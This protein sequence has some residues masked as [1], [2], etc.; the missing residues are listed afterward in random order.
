MTTKENLIAQAEAAVRVAKR[1]VQAGAWKEIT[2]YQAQ[3][4]LN[5]LMNEHYVP[6]VRKTIPAVDQ[7]S[8]ARPMNLMDESRQ[9]VSDAQAASRKVAGLS[10]LLH[11]TTGQEK[12]L[13]LKQL[14]VSNI[15][16][17]QKWS[18]YFYFKRNGKKMD[19]LTSEGKKEPEYVNNPEFLKLERDKN[20]AMQKRSRLKGRLERDVLSDK[21]RNEIE[22]LFAKTNMEIAAMVEKI[23]QLKDG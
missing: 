19:V 20:L 3:E 6:E 18:E 10:N 23:K 1:K 2:I 17:E 11:C 16:K 12:V 8:A 7:Y 9:L 15:L 13:L 21:Q 22:E 4:K 5:N 14:S